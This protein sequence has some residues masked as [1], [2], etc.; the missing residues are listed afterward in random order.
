MV[1]Q[2]SP[3]YLTFNLLHCFCHLF[4]FICLF[5]WWQELSET[6][7]YLATQ[8]HSIVASFSRECPTRVLLVVLLKAC[9][10]TGIFRSL[11][12]ALSKDGEPLPFHE[13]AA[14]GLVC[15]RCQHYST[16][17]W[18]ASEFAFVL[19]I[20]LRMQLDVYECM[21][22]LDCLQ[23][24]G[25]LGSLVGNPA[26]LALLRMQADGVLPLVQRRH[27]KYAHTLR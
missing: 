19:Q 9:G 4:C 5:V 22:L 21:N 24:A 14:C 20:I 2:K 6:V 10:S 11:S 12:D 1:Q 27:Y 23:V 15:E 26:D 25:A 17:T 3:N 8:G 13:K 18:D 7:L 16:Y